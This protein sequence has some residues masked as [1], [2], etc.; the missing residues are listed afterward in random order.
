MSTASVL[1]SRFDASPLALGL[2]VGD[3]LGLTAFVVAG[4]IAHGEQPF[5]NPGVVVAALAPFLIGWAVVALPV[6]L[7]TADAVAHPWRVVRRTLPAWIVAVLLGHGLRAT[8]VFRGGTAITFVVVTLLVGGALV[9][10]WRFLLATVR[11]LR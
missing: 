6:G 1:R 3:L 5:Q 11:Y 4:A 2:A 9:V 8:P 10:G 7:Y